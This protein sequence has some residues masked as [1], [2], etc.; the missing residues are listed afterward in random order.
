MDFNLA[1]VRNLVLGLFFSG[2][3]C[4]VVPLAADSLV[5]DKLSSLRQC[6]TPPSWQFPR[7]P[8][9][10]ETLVW[11]F[12]LLVVACCLWL[13]FWEQ[14]PWGLFASTLVLLLSLVVFRLL[15]EALTQDCSPQN[16]DRANHLAVAQWVSSIAGAICVILAAIYFFAYSREHSMSSSHFFDHENR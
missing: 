13:A 6:A 16:R 10:D 14:A 4:C 12:I 2:V 7:N 8:L 3:W 15:T 1:T 9:G 5:C 11:S